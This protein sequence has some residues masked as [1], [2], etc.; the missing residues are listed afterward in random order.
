MRHSTTEGKKM[1]Q[2]DTSQV[3]FG[4][5]APWAAEIFQI[6]KKDLKGE[7]LR[8][9]PQFARKHFQKKNIEKLTNEDLVQASVQE[10]SDGNEAFA[11]WAGAR[12]VMKNAEI[13]Q[14]FALELT[15]INPQFDQI[16]LIPENVELSMIKTAV[17][18]FG[19]KR[20]YIFSILNAVRFSPKGYEQ[21]R[22]QAS[23]DV[24]TVAEAKEEGESIESVKA[25]YESMIQK[26]TDKYERRLQGQEKKYAVD[27]EGMRKQ[28]SQLHKK[29]G[30]LASVR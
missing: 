30:E 15:K 8:Q 26:I 4:M 10:I 24:E 6:I 27:M 11:E 21:L 25:R 7:Y 23:L 20:V 22:A 19:A 16:E 17:E 12:W 3:K 1:I 18:S 29:L 13:Y 5:L 14:F 28:I 9:N 2:E